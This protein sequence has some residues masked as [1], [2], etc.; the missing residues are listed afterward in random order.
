MTRHPFQP[1]DLAVR[2]QDPYPVDERDK[3]EVGLLYFIEKIMTKANGTRC[4][5]V[6]GQDY[7][8]AWHNANCFRH[9]TAEDLMRFGL[10]LGYVPV[11]QPM[12]S[13]RAPA[14]LGKAAS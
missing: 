5:R 6:M 4:V 2:V 1:R 7:G 8:E 11:F 12:P 10:R 13:G 3:T 9:V 14:W